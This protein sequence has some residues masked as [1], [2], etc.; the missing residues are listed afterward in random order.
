MNVY[1]IKKSL[2]QGLSSQLQKA[3]C[4]F[5]LTAA[6][7]SVLATLLPASCRQNGRSSEISTGYDKAPTQTDTAKS[8]CPVWKELGHRKKHMVTSTC[9]TEVASL[10]SGKLSSVGLWE[11]QDSN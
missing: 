4:L 3:E 1:G 9:L 11:G 6:T 10:A 2:V 5:C 8:H 7:Y